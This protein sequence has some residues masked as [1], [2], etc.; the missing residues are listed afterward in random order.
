M[1]QEYLT[2]PAFEDLSLPF[3]SCEA[4]AAALVGRVDN[5]FHPA[6]MIIIAMIPILCKAISLTMV[7]RKRYRRRLSC[8]R[9][10]AR[11]I[12]CGEGKGSGQPLGSKPNRPDGPI[13]PRAALHNLLL[14]GREAR[15]SG[16]W[17]KARVA[18][19]PDIPER[20]FSSASQRSAPTVRTIRMTTRRIPIRGATNRRYWSKPTFASARPAIKIAFVGRTSLSQ[21]ADADHVVITSA[22]STPG[23]VAERRQAPEL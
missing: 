13:R 16:P 2:T 20:E 15:G 12:A 17:L 5:A 19:T 23:E 4:D 8:W 18:P 11:P 6:T 21:P 14:N 1:P 7:N 9:S 3:R 10:G 22:R